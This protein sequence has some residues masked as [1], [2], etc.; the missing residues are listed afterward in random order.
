MLHGSNQTQLKSQLPG[1]E[2]THCIQQAF[3]KFTTV[4]QKK[5]KKMM[6]IKFVELET[7]QNIQCEFFFVVLGSCKLVEIKTLVAARTIE[8]LI[9]CE[10]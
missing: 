6:E 3:E 4:K 7:P 1:S 5:K 10:F 2:K 8:A 9:Y